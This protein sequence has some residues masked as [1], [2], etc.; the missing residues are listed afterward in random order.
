MRRT[1]AILAFLVLS[2]HAV[3]CIR[4]KFD[5]FVAQYEALNDNYTGLII[6]STSSDNTQEK[7]TFS[8]EH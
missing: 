4:A 8:N 2:A 5:I 7:F 3:D 1:L 6:D